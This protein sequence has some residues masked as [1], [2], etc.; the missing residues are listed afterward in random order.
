M[1]PTYRECAMQRGKETMA[2]MHQI[3]KT[4]LDK[5]DIFI[6]I[7]KRIEHKLQALFD[8]NVAGMLEDI[9]ELCSSI[10]GQ[11]AAFIGPLAEA[12]KKNP[13]E[14]DKVRILTGRG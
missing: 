10:R 5:R 6:H 13:E 3:M 2:R 4:R 7:H 1:V 9:T 8:E 14:V 12:Q 11:V